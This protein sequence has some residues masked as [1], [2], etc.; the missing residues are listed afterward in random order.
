MLN[1]I[2]AES[3]RVLNAVL[4]AGG[5]TP[6]E[7]TIEISPEKTISATVEANLVNPVIGSV[8]ADLSPLQAD[9][10]GEVPTRVA[11]TKVL[12]NSVAY[13]ESVGDTIPS[14]ATI[15]VYADYKVVE[16]D[17]VPVTIPGVKIADGIRDIATL[18]FITDF[19][20]IELQDHINNTEIH[21]TQEERERWNNTD[22]SLRWDYDL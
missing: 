14:A 20:M 5:L 6:V 10:S 19:I 16:I 2:N 17:G 3:K 9:I 11:T 7:G 15:I 4:T 18:P 21:I 12:M 22:F 1:E 13:W 8:L